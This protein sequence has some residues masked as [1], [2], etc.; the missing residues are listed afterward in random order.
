MFKYH[1]LNPIANIG[2]QRFTNDYKRVED[3]NEAQ[4]ILVRSASMHEMELSDKLLAVARAGA[5]VNNIPLEKCAEKGIVVF[6][7]PG[8]NANGVKELVFA[9]MLLASRDVVGGI[10]WV[11]SAKD[12]ENIAKAAEKEKKKFAGT[13]IEGKKLG[14]IGLGAIGVKVA[15]AATHLG[16]EV[17]GY[18]PYVSVDAAWNLSRSVKHV[19]NV[20]EIY[21]ECD[22]ITIHVPALPTTKGMINS[23]AIS[24]MKDGVIILNFARDVLVNEEDV[25]EAIEAGKVRKYVSDFPNP[26]T[27]GKEGCIVIPHLGASTEE[28]EDNCAVMAVKEL[29]NYLENGNIVNSVNFPNC[30]MGICSQAGRVAVFH[31]NSSGMISKFTT[32]FGNHGINITDMT[33][34]S[35]G[36]WAYTMLDLEQPVSDEVVAELKASEGVVR[37]RVVK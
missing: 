33:N 22:F 8:A 15:N 1:C 24:L 27:A 6:N 14:I 20:E 19:L 30:D 10:E 34:K 2:L 25:L 36:E 37:V 17:Y 4:G 18:D 31:K 3:V 35:R 16:M 26:T 7:T 13:E 28:S 11:K 29:K 5:G 12:D 9:G 32:V 23:D 21:E